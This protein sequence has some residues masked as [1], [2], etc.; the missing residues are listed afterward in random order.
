MTGEE[1][2]NSVQEVTEIRQLRQQQQEQQR[3]QQMQL[4][5]AQMGLEQ[6]RALSF[7]SQGQKNL[8]D[9]Q[10]TRQSL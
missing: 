10:K 5:Q 9:A 3:Q 1:H 6:A 2:V 8:A 4:L 7:G